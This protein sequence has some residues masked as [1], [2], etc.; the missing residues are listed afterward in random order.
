MSSLP[1]TLSYRSQY[2]H[3]I[4]IGCESCDGPWCLF[5]TRV[6]S[7]MA[8]Q[9]LALTPCTKSWS[10]PQHDYQPAWPPHDGVAMLS[11]KITQWYK[12]TADSPKIILVLNTQE[13]LTKINHS[14]ILYYTVHKYCVWSHLCTFHCKNTT[15]SAVCFRDLLHCLINFLSQYLLSLNTPPVLS[16]RMHGVWTV[17]MTRSR[18]LQCP[19]LWIQTL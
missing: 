16:V 4:C 11:I 5:N 9:L 3:C 8:R 17:N 6:P 15:P 10:L 2:S 13:W 1:T 19:R 14:K 18:G 7:H 12:W